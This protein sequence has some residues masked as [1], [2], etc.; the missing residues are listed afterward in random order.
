MIN[1]KCDC[2][3]KVSSRKLAIV[4]DTIYWKSSSYE[5]VYNCFEKSRGPWKVEALKK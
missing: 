1:R 3:K 2:E 5:N 4:K